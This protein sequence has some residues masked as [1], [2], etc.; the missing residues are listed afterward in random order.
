MLEWGTGLGF[1]SVTVL[2]LIKKSQQLKTIAALK[3]D[4]P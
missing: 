2:A 3:I 1:V 4:S